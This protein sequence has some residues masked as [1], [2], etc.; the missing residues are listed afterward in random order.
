MTEP[1]SNGNGNG[2]GVGLSGSDMLAL[3]SHITN[4]LT[5]M[6]GR[7]MGR[8][9]RN[10]AGASDR[11]ALHE[12]KHDEELTTNTKRVV[13]RFLLVE[14]KLAE[15]EADL[16]QAT[17]CLTDHLKMEERQHIEAEIRVRPL[18]AV[19]N[20]VITNWK[21]IL[22]LIAA[23]LVVMGIIGVEWKQ[24]SGG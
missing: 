11:W 20:F 19:R 7:I 2:N 16:T 3:L 17:K 15:V 4:L 10:A 6:E 12:K 1:N 9:D 21:D 13:D 8:L 5:D 14:G 22:I 18:I 23:I 24:I